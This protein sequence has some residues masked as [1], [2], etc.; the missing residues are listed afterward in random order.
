MK[1]INSF[2][3]QIK[4]Y[5]L[6]AVL[7]S[8]PENVRYL[9]GFIGTNGQLFITPT[10]AS[11][12]TDFRYFTSA[13][14]QLPKEM[15]IY[16]QSKGLKKLFGRVKSVGFED[17][18]F[19]VSNLKAYKKSLP[20]V[21]FVPL[22]YVVDKIRM[23][24]SEYEIRQI[25]KIVKIAEKAFADFVK[26]IKVGQSEDE[27][28]WNLLSAGRRHGADE[29]SFPPIICFGKN[30]SDVHH[31]KSTNKLKKK[32]QILVD[33]GFKLNGYC[34]DSTRMIH[35]N[36]ANKFEH[37]IYSIVLEANMTAINSIRVDKKFSDIDKVA[38]DIIEKEGYG[39]Y[40][41]HSTGHGI[42][43][44]VHELPNISINSKDVVMPG[45]VFTIEPGIY[46]EGKGGVRIEDMVYVDAKGKVE[47]LTKFT[48]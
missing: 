39:E 28:E 29:F 20:G 30:T 1:R 43:L 9:S 18:Y 34:S 10:K 2:Q 35:L 22:G 4:K 26:T 24:K 40:F 31:Q 44:E 42:G 32:E 45:M 19:T 41:G 33:Y 17:H 48:K 3:N 7:I 6:G 23:I 36:K 16:D 8:K 27:M 12:I 37:K 38:R 5:K 15:V 46:V 14:K 13:K 21:K 25:R 47:V 11:L